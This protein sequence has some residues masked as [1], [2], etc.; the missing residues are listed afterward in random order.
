MRI[1]EH[2]R[3]VCIDRGR[4]T[5]CAVLCF[6]LVRYRG[7]TESATDR[8]PI[9]PFMK[10]AASRH[11]SRAASNVPACPMSFAMDSSTAV[12]VLGAS[13][14]RLSHESHNGLDARTKFFHA[15]HL[16]GPVT[17]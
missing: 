2:N 7:G 4:Q 8:R 15:I 16:N 9:P 1:D 13:Y 3:R 14:I 6:N 17:A 10:T 11:S 12:S 5:R